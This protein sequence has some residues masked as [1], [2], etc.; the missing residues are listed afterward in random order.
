MKGRAPRPPKTIGRVAQEGSREARR[1]AAVIL[2][3]L[4]GV[5]LPSEAAKALEVSLPRYYSL[6]VK[7]VEGLLRA[8]EPRKGGGRA[9][10]PARE[11]QMLRQE[12]D[13]LER[14]TARQQALLRVAQRAVGLSSPKPEK[15][16]GK[17]GKKRRRRKP[18]TR[19]LRAAAA[20]QPGEEACQAAAGGS[21]QG[22]AQEAEE[23]RSAS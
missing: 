9:R 22:A 16:E 12:V 17:D 15:K 2:E 4:G 10:S 3:V 23:R 20:L 13:R 14:E 21:I 18:A 1:L 6:E 7:A 8:C 5:R 11:M 19:A